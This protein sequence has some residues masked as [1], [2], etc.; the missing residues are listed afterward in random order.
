M[1]PSCH[2]Y[3]KPKLNQVNTDSGEQYRDTGQQGKVPPGLESCLLEAENPHYF[4][5][6]CMQG[7]V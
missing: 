2:T 1:M 3:F 6:N 4:T 7:D 5:W